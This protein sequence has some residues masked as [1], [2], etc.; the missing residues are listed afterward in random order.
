MPSSKV[1]NTNRRGAARPV[2]RLRTGHTLAITAA[3]IGLLTLFFQSLPEPEPSYQGDFVIGPVTVF[4]DGRF[5]TTPLY[6]TIDDGVIRAISADKPAL[7]LP[8]ITAEGGTLL[9]GLTDA[10]VHTYG[11]ALEQQLRAGVTS[12]LDMFMA[13]ELLKTQLTAQLQPQ[14]IAREAS[15]YSAGVL[16]TAPKGHGTEYSISIPTLTSPAQAEAFVRD[17]IHEGSAYLKIVYQSAK[18]PFKRMPSIDKATLTALIEA[19]HH[20]GRI[21]VVHIADQ[22][23]AQEAVDAG[24]DG[25][26]HSFFDSP[27]TTELLHAL[28]QRKVFVI[29]TM[30]VYDANIG[31]QLNQRFADLIRNIRPLTRREEQGLAPLQRNPLLPP[32][33]VKNLYDNVRQMQQA[34]VVL[35]AGTDAPNS[36]TLHGLS[37]QAEL[38]ALREVGLSTEQALLAASRTPLRQFGITDRGEIAVG[39]QAD[40]VLLGKGDVWQ[41]L[42]QPQR[43]WHRGLAVNLQHSQNQALTSAVLAD[44]SEQPAGPINTDPAQ[45]GLAAGSVRIS[46]G[47]AAVQTD[48]RFGG[49]STVQA[50]IVLA[51][52]Q[53]DAGERVTSQPSAARDTRTTTAETPEQP[54]PVLDLLTQL[55]ASSAM[56]WAGFSWVPFEQFSRAVDVT[57]ASHLRFRIKGDAAIYRLL[58]I[59]GEQMQ[60]VGIDVP[61][62]PSWQTVEIDL[63]TQKGVDSSAIKVLLWSAPAQAGQYHWQL[64]DIAL[65]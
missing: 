28:V 65:R 36:G 13:P 60:P 49:K 61:V 18:A 45:G 57:Q 46:K 22:V 14:T 33:L 25:L 48:A 1:T 19:A 50:S 27:I 54:N 5:S 51:P 7:N 41:Q 43:V 62:T 11:N 31:G 17:R 24:A 59:S 58:V 23:S 63:A 10:H 37:L 32:H 12:V 55:D 44:F 8:L 47:F 42:T 3:L 9:P 30:A 21:A 56:P 40:L 53:H 6:V 29:P 35:L 2:S 39:Q 26:V 34:G 64:D 4:Q 16:A 52:S 20:H 38:L 15:L